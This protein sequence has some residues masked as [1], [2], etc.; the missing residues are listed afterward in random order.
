MRVE[1]IEIVRSRRR[2]LALQV[3]G[4]GH[5]VARAPL[6][7]PLSEIYAFA[8]SKEAWLDEKVALRKALASSQQPKLTADE[9][10]A[11]LRQARDVIPQRVSHYAPLV[12]V[13]CRSVTRRFQRT[14]WGSCSSTGGLNFNCLLML[15]PSEVLDYVVVHELCHRKEMNHSARF[16]AEVE[17]VCPDWR[18]HRRWLREKGTALLRRV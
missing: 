10:K 16:W 4:E 8:R 15:A 3:T 12:G 14:R 2:T 17:R 11:L 18:L 7:M 1:E 5:I 6:R 9:R 13:S